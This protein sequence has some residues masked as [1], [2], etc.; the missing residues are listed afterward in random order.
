MSR[1]KSEG[2]LLGPF[3]F[4]TKGEAE[5]AIREVA[6]SADIGNPV[7]GE[8]KELILGLLERH[9][10]AARKIGAGV[11][12]VVVRFNAYKKRGFYLLRVD[13]SETDFSWTKCLSPPRPIDRVRTALRSCIADQKLEARDRHF[14]AGANACCELTGLAITPASCHVHHENPTFAELV[15]AFLGARGI[16]SEAVAFVRVDGVEGP[17]L[18]AEWHWLG[19]EFEA[20]HRTHA[21]MLVVHASEHMHLPK[22]RPRR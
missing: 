7:I 22:V 2:L 13:G 14:A 11:S 20:Y 16:S 1:T 19:R 3:E 18:A 4:R 15:D 5:A 8:A 17:R 21:R 6:D 9:P 12:Q 10:E